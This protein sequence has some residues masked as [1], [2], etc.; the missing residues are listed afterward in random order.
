MAVFWGRLPIDILW[1]TTISSLIGISVG[2][3]ACLGLK[4]CRS[5]TYSATYETVFTL[6]MGFVSYALGD[7]SKASGVISCIITGMVLAVF[8]WYSMSP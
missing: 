6:C 5:L 3:L 4:Y 1:Y 8:G 7:Y 2:A